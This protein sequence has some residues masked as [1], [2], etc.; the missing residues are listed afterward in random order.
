MKRAIVIALVLVAC[1]KSA[2]EQAKEDS[3]REAAAH[4]TAPET[5]PEKQVI[6]TP[7]KP[8]PPPEPEPTT[9]EEIDRARNQAMIDGRDKDV[10]KYCAM[11]KLDDKSNPQ[12][13]LGCALAAC[14]LNNADTAKTYAAPLP[15][16][17]MDQARHVCAT[18][19]VDL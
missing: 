5:A 3:E 17:L 6:G 15:K 14:R 11:Q 19:K 13:L 8:K 9:P 10:L 16:A 12:A 7:D 1:G 2:E 18:Y 4:R